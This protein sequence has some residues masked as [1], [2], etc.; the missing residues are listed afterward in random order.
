[1]GSIGS[2]SVPVEGRLEEKRRAEN[3]PVALRVL[4]ARFRTHL[5]AVYAFA[6]TVDDLGDEA[7]GDRTARL[8]AF[9]EDLARVWDG[10]PETPVLRGLTETVRS[11]R[12]PP[13]PFDRL[14][15]ANLRD[16]RQTS[17]ATFGDLRDYCTL[18]ADP[19]GRIVLGVFDVRDAEA[20]RLSD[21]IC[22]GLQLVEHLQDVA[23]DRRAGRVYLPADDMAAHGVAAADLDG[24][25]TPPAV[26]RLVGLSSVRAA[27]WLTRGAPLLPRLRGWARLA[28][29][30]YLAGGYAAL[31]ALRRV[32][33]AVLAGT[34]RARRRDVLRHLV[35]LLPRPRAHALAE[36][37]RIRRH[38][39]RGAA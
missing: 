26:R 4:P 9:R 8:T 37:T 13:E 23:E 36:L 5:I 20:E 28:V 3:F 16:Q 1:V 38:V 35:L 14:V 34:P 6:R 39:R 18:S 21:H 32:D 31:D 15:R 19:V 11:C 7:G 30:G 27:E 25:V 17:Y 2:G 10:E 33:F 24:T 22:T 29:T 12:L